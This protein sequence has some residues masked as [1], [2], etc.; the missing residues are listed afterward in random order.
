M[1]DL[2]AKINEATS[3]IIAK[4]SEI[5]DLRASARWHESQAQLDRARC[6]HLLREIDELN[7]VV[8]HAQVAQS[9]VDAEKA[10]HAAK[11]EAEKLTKELRD[12]QN[13]LDKL[14]AQK[15]AGL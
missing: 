8:Q 7:A 14:I 3:Q 11:N 1:N 2:L 5:A 15:K 13:E 4:R 10:A 9:A 12:K 6:V